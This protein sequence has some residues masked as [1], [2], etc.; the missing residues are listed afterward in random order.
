[1]SVENVVVIA[2]H[3]DDETLGCGGTLLRHR[4]ET[5][6]LFWLILT[7]MTP[8]RFSA[9]AIAARQ[10]EILAVQEHYGFEQVFELGHPAGALD[11]VAMSDLVASIGDVFGSVQPGT[12][13][14]PAR[15]DAHTDHR[16]AFDAAAACTKWFRY[17]Y[18]K[19]VRVYETLSETDISLTSG[20]R[21]NLYVDVTS[22]IDK[23][24][25]AMRI[26]RSEIGVHPFPRSVDT[27]RSLATLRGAASGFAAAEA[28][29]QL[30]ER[31]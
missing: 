15:S 4:E 11:R 1:M 29:D 26:Y 8:D 6:R 20:W 21:P 2:P 16:I 25:D 27:I 30:L 14:L 13:Y 23:K 17:P 10:G 24:I 9:D 22:H 19:R 7:R 3:P 5:C 12:V 28:F 18:V 31:V